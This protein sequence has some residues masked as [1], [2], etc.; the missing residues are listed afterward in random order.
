M[1]GLTGL[2]FVPALIAFVV[3]SFKFKQPVDLVFAADAVRFRF[4]FRAW[5][6]RPVSDLERIYLEPVQARLRWGVRVTYYTL[7]LRF[8]GG[9]SLRIGQDRAWQFGYSPDRLHAAIGQLYRL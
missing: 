6:A 9:P 5:Q 1:F 2:I 4:P 7:V 8:V 3:G